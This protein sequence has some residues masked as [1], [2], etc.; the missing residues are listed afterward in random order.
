MVTK[1]TVVEIFSAVVQEKTP[2]RHQS[3]VI[4]SRADGEG[5]RTRRRCDTKHDVR[6]RPHAFSDKITRAVVRSFAV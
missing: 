4:L 6:P 5:P 1:G 3:T 2:S